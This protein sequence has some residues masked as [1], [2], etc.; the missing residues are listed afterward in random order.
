MRR[1]ETASSLSLEE[2]AVFVVGSRGKYPEHNKIENYRALPGKITKVLL[3]EELC[4]RLTQAAC[5][6]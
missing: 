6:D 5:E 2:V 1:A 3:G 4:G